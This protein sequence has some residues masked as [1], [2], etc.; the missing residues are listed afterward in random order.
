M[1]YGA[2]DDT[3]YNT[4]S[5][6]CV[7]APRSCRVECVCLILRAIRAGIRCQEMLR[8]IASARMRELRD[9][10]GARACA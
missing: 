10:R 9:S 7:Y 4:L 5:A 3:V 8:K 6:A 1:S 2:G